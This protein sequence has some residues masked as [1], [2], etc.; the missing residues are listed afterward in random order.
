[1][2]CFVN[3]YLFTPTRH[4][5]FR[6][7]VQ[8]EFIVRDVFYTIYLLFKF[9]LLKKIY[10]RRFLI[11]IVRAVVSKIIYIGECL[12]SCEYFHVKLHQIETWW[13]NDKSLLHRS[14]NS[15]NSVRWKKRAVNLYFGRSFS[16][17]PLKSQSCWIIFH[18]RTT[19]RSLS[20]FASTGIFRACVAR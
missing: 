2:D 10:H 11:L 20:K 9:W 16:L 5:V 3:F 19:L 18:N 15:A 17:P 14:D 7:I 13:T 4:Y 6:T 12:F 1:M 8:D